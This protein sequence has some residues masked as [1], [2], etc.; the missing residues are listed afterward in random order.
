MKLFKNYTFTWW[1]MGAIKLYVL[2][3][4]IILGAYWA[5]FFS[6]YIPQF[7]G[8]ALILVVYIVSISAKKILR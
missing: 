8:I 4:G 7:L 2:S 6:Q 3:V 1:Q 5:D